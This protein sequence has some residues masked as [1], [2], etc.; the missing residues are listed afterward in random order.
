MVQYSDGVVAQA[1]LTPSS[2]LRACPV[3]W[4]PAL[5]VSSVSFRGIFCV[6]KFT[7]TFPPL[8]TQTGQTI[9]GFMPLVL[10]A[11][12][13]PWDELRALRLCRVLRCG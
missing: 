9:P 4:P 1:P 2:L 6:N 12:N 13:T 5:S 7:D 3:Q 10:F 11:Q 8:L